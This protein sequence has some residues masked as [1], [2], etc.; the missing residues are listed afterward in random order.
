V[1]PSLW[2]EEAAMPEEAA[3]VAEGCVAIAVV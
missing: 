2:D 1:S 3:V